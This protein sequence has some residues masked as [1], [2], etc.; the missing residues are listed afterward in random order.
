MG[1]THWHRW[2]RRLASGS[3]VLFGG[4]AAMIALLMPLTVATLTQTASGVTTTVSLSPLVVWSLLAGVVVGMTL[5]LLQMR[6]EYR[7]RTYDPTWVLKFGDAFN[8]KEMKC[9]RSN[10]AAVLQ[11]NAGNLRRSEFKSPEIDEVLDFF[12]DL[13]FYMQGDQITPEVGHHAFH[14]WIRGY[15][16]A[17]RD[18]LDVAQ[19]TEPTRWEFVKI[20]FDTTNEIEAERSK[21]RHKKFLDATDLA[22]FLD[23]EIKLV[24]PREE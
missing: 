10:A 24:T 4:G 16:S 3:P 20:L 22:D 15:Y 21:G 23:A 18:Y 14:D 2:R 6:A 17:A 5:L 7:R 1:K 8:S 19:E 12:E 13:G 11:N 9:T